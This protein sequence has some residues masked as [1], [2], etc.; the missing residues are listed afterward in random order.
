MPRYWVCVDASFALRLL[1]S[2]GPES[3]AAQL[4]RSWKDA[5]RTP[6]AP[7]LVHY[8]ITNVLH[9]YERHGYLNTDEAEALL[10]IALSLGIRLFTDPILHEEA[11]QISRQMRLSA[12]YDA[13]YL[14]LS[15][16]LGTELWTADKKLVRA[17][18]DHFPEVHLLRF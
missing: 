3:H 6:V 15:R 2:E 17:V 1:L 18:R 11:L 14:A 13:H 5:G 10:Q 16:R 8:E 4:W 9:R 12:T 7:A